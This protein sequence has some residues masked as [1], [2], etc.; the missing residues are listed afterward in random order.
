M[1]RAVLSLIDDCEV[2]VS[3]GAR[4]ENSAEG[5]LPCG[6]ADSVHLSVPIII[7][8]RRREFWCENEPGCG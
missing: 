1:E 8:M 5:Q 3:F 2:A 4:R 7:P 6:K